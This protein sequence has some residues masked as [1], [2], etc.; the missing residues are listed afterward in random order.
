MNKIRFVFLL[1]ILSAGFSL[2][3]QD[4][5]PVKVDVKTSPEVLQPGDKGLLEITFTFP[6]GF[7]QTKTPD[8]FYILPAEGEAGRFLS[9]GEIQYPEGIEEDGLVNYYGKTV[10]SAEI[11]ITGEAPPGYRPKI[12]AGWQICS[13][14]GTCFFPEEQSFPLAANTISKE[15]PP[16]TQS[17]FL[18]LLKFI[19]FAFTGGLLLNVMP[20]VLPILS[21]RALN[22]INQSKNDNRSIFISAMLYGLGVLVSLLVLAVIVIALKFTGQLA[23]W[24]FQFQ[25][26]VFVSVLMVTIFIFSLSLFDVFLINPPGMNSMVRAASKKGY[27]GS[28]FN[29]IFAVLLAT[30]CTAP[31]LG[32]ALGFAFSQSAAFIL[33]SFTAI[34][35]GFALPFILLGLWP[36]AIKALPKPGKWM[37]TFKEL[38][39][40]LLLGTVVYLFSTLRYEVDSDGQLK[41]LLYLLT[42]AFIAWI[43]GKL[44]SPSS[45]VRTSKAA[46]AGAVILLILSGVYFLDFH[47]GTG[48][49]T[50]VQ[51]QVSEVKEGWELFSPENLQ[52]HIDKGNAVLVQFSAKWCT[53]CKVNDR[54]IFNSDKGKIFFRKRDI[55]LLYGDYTSRD[56]VI[57]EW[58]RMYGKA[59]VPVYAYYPPGSS[60]YKVLPEILTWSIIENAVKTNQEGNAV[61]TLDGSSFFSQP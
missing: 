38:M 13:N 7:H 34:G 25:N 24:G 3:A 52:Q 17:G 15:A 45:K 4:V 51:K 44:S 10:L 42:A 40:F 8:F 48:K 11:T 27:I 60:N 2:S 53:V 43:Y 36:A 22:L 32:S 1:I 35:A 12:R 41:V 21:M 47:E 31:F 54:V 59:G 55:A 5:P 6:E 56:P 49:S 50:A 14:E 33:L 30:P 39:G 28:F 37:D 61:K 29:G 20:C 26:P 19:L 9:L 18:T 57:G 46:F 16:K 58:I 23:G